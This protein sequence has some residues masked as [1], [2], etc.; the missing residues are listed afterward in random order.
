MNLVRLL[1]ILN[2]SEKNLTGKALQ[3]SVKKKFLKLTGKPFNGVLST[4]LNFTKSF[5]VNFSIFFQIVILKKGCFQIFIPFANI[6][7]VDFEHA[8]HAWN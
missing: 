1:S 5:L 7:I 4:A 8:L 2:K 3:N 6:F